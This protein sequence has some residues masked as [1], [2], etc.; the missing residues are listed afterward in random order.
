MVAFV[1]AQLAGIVTPFGWYVDEN[2]ALHFFDA[3][4]ATI[5]GVIFTTSPTAAGAGSIGL[6]HVQR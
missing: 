6:E 3:S 1:L 4:S 5:A 2:R